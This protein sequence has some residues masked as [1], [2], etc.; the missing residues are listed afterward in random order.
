[1]LQDKY[2]IS[3]LPSPHNVFLEEFSDNKLDVG[4]IDFV[5]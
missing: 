2:T 3:D 5:D 1:M 4:N